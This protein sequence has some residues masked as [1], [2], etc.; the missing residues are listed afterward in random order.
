MPSPAHVFAAALVS[1]GVVPAPYTN[2]PVVLPEDWNVTDGC[3]SIRILDSK[4]VADQSVM[5]QQAA[6]EIVAWVAPTNVRDG[7][8]HAHAVVQAVNAI[9]APVSTLD[10]QL[11]SAVVLT[12]PAIQ[13]QAGEESLRQIT[14]VVSVHVALSLP[15]QARKVIIDGPQE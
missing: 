14:F 13:P 1:T 5:C 3:R 8:Q 6:L 7:W 10:G 9:Q 12:A 11:L 15:T 2:V 4:V